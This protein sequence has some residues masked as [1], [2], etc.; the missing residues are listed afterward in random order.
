MMTYSYLNRD[1]V[2]S[3]VLHWW[4]EFA[5]EGGAVSGAKSGNYAKNRLGHKQ[6]TFPCS[7]A[8]SPQHQ[9]FISAEW[10]QSEMKRSCVTVSQALRQMGHLTLVLQSY[11][12]FLPGAGVGRETNGLPSPPWVCAR[13]PY[14]LEWSMDGR[15]NRRSTPTERAQTQVVTTRVLSRKKGLFDGKGCGSSLPREPPL[16]HT[17]A[18]S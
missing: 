2:L 11:S 1:C 8:S 16:R 18:T 14:R 5:N 7:A 6:S 4:I 10:S 12:G 3:K 9:L 17:T 13:P 15:D